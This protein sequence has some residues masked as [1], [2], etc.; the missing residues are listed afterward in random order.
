MATSQKGVFAGG[1]VVS[2]PATVIEA[3][4]T[5]RKAAIAIDKYLGGDGIIVSGERTAVKT[6][7]DEAEYLKERPRKVP[8]VLPLE[9]R[10]TGFEEV[11]LRFSLKQAM[12]EARRCLHCDREEE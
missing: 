6:N 2:G 10:K 12:E 8:Q 4:A 5:G 11:R 1:D 7:Y 3:V 9:K